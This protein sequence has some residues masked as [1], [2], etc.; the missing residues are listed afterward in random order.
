[1]TDSK[2]G[3]IEVVDLTMAYGQTVIQHDL[4]FTV[5]RGDIFVIMGGSGCGK[6][7]LLK[8]MLGLM[9]PVRGDILYGG[10]SFFQA[11][12]HEQGAMRQRWGITI[13]R[14]GCLVR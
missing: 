7:T 3:Q 9:T 13:N 8:H 6:S 12:E 4:S 2:K 10:A 11:D 5:N 1:M 14:G